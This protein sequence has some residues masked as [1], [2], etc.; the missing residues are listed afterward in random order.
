MIFILLQ[1]F[2]TMLT[3]ILIH[4]FV[5][6]GKITRDED[7]LFPFNILANVLKGD[8]IA[9]FNIKDNEIIKDK[10]EAVGVDKF[11]DNHKQS[12]EKTHLRG[13]SLAEISLNNL[14]NFL[15]NPSNS[16]TGLTFGSYLVNKFELGDF[17]TGS[18]IFIS[19]E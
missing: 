18:Q 17:N 8:E 11:Y 12:I 14:Y 16:M 7:L 9:S 5:W 1:F 15:V 6:N 19:F 10:K 13:N 4:S 3:W 2:F